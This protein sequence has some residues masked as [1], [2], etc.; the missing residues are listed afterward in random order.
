M[1]VLGEGLAAGLFDFSLKS[2]FQSRSYP[3]Q[4][5]RHLGAEFRLPS[6][7]PPGLGQFEEGVPVSLPDLGQTTLL[8]EFLPP[9]SISNLS[10]PGFTVADALRMHPRPPLIHRNDA[11]QTAV[12][13]LLDPRSVIEGKDDRL[14]TQID[15]AL[16]QR[17]TFL[18]ISLGFGDV[19]GPALRPTEGLPPIEAFRKDYERIL[20]AASTT[21]A[22]VLVMTI[23]V[24]TDTAAFSSLDSA[25]KILKASASSLREVYDLRQDDLLT[26]AGLMEIG[27]QINSRRILPLDRRSV[28][29]G[30]DARRIAG[31]VQSMNREL[32]SLAAKYRAAVCD[33]AGF[34]RRLREQGLSV[35]SRAITADFLGGFYSLNGFT[36]GPTGHALIANEAIRALNEAFSA[37]IPPIDAARLLAEDPVATHQVSTGRDWTLAELRSFARGPQSR[38]SC[39]AASSRRGDQTGQGRVRATPRF[40]TMEERYNAIYRDPPPRPLQLPSGL[41]QTLPLV[42]D[43][44]YIGEVFSAINAP[45]GSKYQATGTP[46]LLFGGLVM[47][48]GALSGSIRITFTAPT[49][50]MTHFEVSLEGGLSGADGLFVAPEFYR[51]PVLQAQLQ[52]WPGMSC[53]GDLNLQTGETSQLSFNILVL[54]SAHAA[55]ERVNPNRPNLPIQYP[56]PYGTALARFIQRADGKLDFIFSGTAF[57]PL[58]PAARLPLPLESASNDFATIAAG[59]TVFHPHLHLSTTDLGVCEDLPRGLAFPANSVQEFTARVGKTDFGDDFTLNSPVLGFA[60]G[61]APLVG[62]VLIQF[63]QASG[64]RVPFAVS[65]VPPGGNLF[66]QDIT[67]IQALFPG[68]LYQG[69]IGHDSSL[70]FPLRHY[71]TIDSFLMDDPFDIAWGVVNAR[72]GEVVGDF[73]HRAFFGHSVFMALVRV[74][75]RTPKGSFEY[76]G[77]ALFE[78]TS[79]GRLR[80]RFNGSVFLPYPE[81]FLFPAPNLAKGFEIGANSRLD[82]FFQVEADSDRRRGAVT[83]SGG[84]NLLLSTTGGQFS[85][86]YSISSD[87]T[88]HKPLFEYTNHAQGG[89]FRLKSLSWV[90]FANSGSRSADGGIETITFSGFGTWSLDPKEALHTASVQVSVAPSSPYVSILIDGGQVSNVITQLKSTEPPLTGLPSESTPRR[91]GRSVQAGESA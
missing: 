65:V 22:S 83:R 16:R 69:M 60:R 34:F 11:K 72:S 76:R 87:P 35:D 49:G 67:P 66:R 21:R 71:P 33:L 82:P 41:E 10:V 48:S 7:E 24:P 62:R 4:L 8:G 44:S 52:V 26:V 50:G 45:Q 54:D 28:L 18:I 20:K 1:V 78:S 53:S 68:R 47:Y 77:P 74:E 31:H 5:A 81:G 17:P 15:C 12:N 39:P 58:G 30:P 40:R 86:R 46:D 59:G 32:S 64:D 29:H 70:G 2:Q 55:L 3:A 85:Y 25:A 37:S 9:P 75:P 84:A 6:I 27:C 56:G 13:L 23:P 51:F 14:G 80:Y 43:S 88:Q 19:L 91:R 79:D 89:T 90:D 63:G 38:V 36:P 61:R 73:L 57:R 42:S